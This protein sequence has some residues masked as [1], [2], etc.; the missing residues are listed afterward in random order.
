MWSDTAGDRFSRPAQ[1]TA[2]YYGAVGERLT[3]RLHQERLAR[4]LAAV[5]TV[6]ERAGAAAGDARCRLEDV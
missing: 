6:T 5:G 2:W 1:C 3:T 4:D